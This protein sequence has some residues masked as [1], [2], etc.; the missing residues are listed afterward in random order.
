MQGRGAGVCESMAEEMMG[1][2]KE[3]CVERKQ[4]VFGLYFRS[5]TASARSS[6]AEQ[7]GTR[8]RVRH[9]SSNGSSWPGDSIEQLPSVL[10][11]LRRNIVLVYTP[12]VFDPMEL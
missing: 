2:E 7:L 11:P 9:C 6:R 8:N 10:T 3:T 5:K 12:R 1:R 4:E